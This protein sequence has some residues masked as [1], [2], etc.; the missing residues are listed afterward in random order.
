MS[1]NVHY[2]IISIRENFRIGIS[3]AEF[4]LDFEYRLDLMCPVQISD[5]I[6]L[7]WRGYVS[8][9]SL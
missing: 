6:D 7:Y 5:G 3:E 8:I 4:L 1:K 2:S 9:F